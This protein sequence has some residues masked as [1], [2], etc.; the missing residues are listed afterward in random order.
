MPTKNPRLNVVLD[1]ELYEVIEKIAK[2]EGKSMSV[3]AKELM[4][5]ALEKHEDMLLSEMAMKRESR[6]KKT[7]S[8][9][10][11]WK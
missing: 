2:Q 3:V 5:N 10:K 11:A 1:S 9:V 8:H 4:E 7:L 6:S